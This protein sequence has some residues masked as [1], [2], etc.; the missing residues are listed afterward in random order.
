MLK[1]RKI[2]NICL[3]FE[4]KNNLKQKYDYIFIKIEKNSSQN[5]NLIQN[6]K[7]SRENNNINDIYKK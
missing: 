4:W 1:K 6:N 5:T 3:N 2:K 7:N